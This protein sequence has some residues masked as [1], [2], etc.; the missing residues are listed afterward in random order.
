MAMCVTYTL[1]LHSKATEN[2]DS[3]GSCG[4]DNDRGGGN[5]VGDVGGVISQNI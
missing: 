1:N 3:T 5:A 4:G 2:G